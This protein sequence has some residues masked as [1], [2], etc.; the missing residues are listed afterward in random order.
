[1]IFRNPEQEYFSCRDWTKSIFFGFAKIDLP[2]VAPIGVGTG[3]PAWPLDTMDRLYL[4]IIFGGI[5]LLV[6]AL[7]LAA[8]ED[9]RNGRAD[10]IV[11][12][13]APQR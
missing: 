7:A 1:M 11:V 13:H 9:S 2:V 6:T 12:L 4:A 8:P 3:R 10:D 5:V